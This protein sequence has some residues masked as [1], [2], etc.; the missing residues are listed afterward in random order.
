[1]KGIIL[2]FNIRII[3]IISIDPYIRIICMPKTWT[4]KPPI[5][6]ELVKQRLHIQPLVMQL[7]FNLGIIA[8]ERIKAFLTPNYESLHD[9]FV[10][11]DME[12]AVDRI[13]RA[14]DAGEKIVVYGDYDADAVTANAVLQQTF[15]Y[16]NVPAESYIPD[17]FTE[18]YG[19]NVP[20]FE[21]LKSDGARVV[22]TVDCG[23]NS[24]DAAD[25]CTSHDID[26]IITDHHEITGDV[27]KSFALINPKNPSDAYPDNQITG[28]GVAYKL[29]VGL[30]SRAEKV[31]A[32]RTA[33]GQDYVPH[34]DKWLL[35]LVAI[36]TVADCHSLL[37]ENRILVKYGLHV[38]G[39]TKWLG[40]R[41]LMEA[42]GVNSPGKTLDTHS[43]GFVIAPRINAAGRLEHAGRALDLLLATDPLKARDLTIQLEQINVRRQDITVRLVSEGKE[44]AEHMLDRKV[45]VLA[46]NDW[47]K[48]VVGLVAGR[49][50]NEFKRPVIA[51]SKEGDECTGSAR[52]FG[53][54]DI[55]ECLKSS[56]E[57]LVKFGGHK[58]A[59]GLT[60]K[61]KDL[62][63]FYGAVLRY[64]DE[65]MTETSESVL[66]LDAELQSTDLSINTHDL[67]AEL[68]PFGVGNPKPIF[69]LANC[70]VETQRAV[71]SDQQHLQMAL[72][73]DGVPVESI[74][75]N[76]AR[77]CDTIK[78]GDTVDIA[79]ELLADAWNGYR[80]FKL[81]IVDIK[82]HELL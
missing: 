6:E 27:P 61:T 5:P 10:F 48:G 65:H 59:A 71:G 50:C 58:Q 11:V 54:F 52:T 1:M 33:A 57:F 29:A 35:D 81:R 62:D 51:L 63:A 46:A 56:K 74:G 72:S 49:L 34:W 76:L 23:T 4:L 43:I 41:S 53:D 37:G 30:L 7:L 20:A 66:E 75:F 69:L 68:G 22:I 31:K 17:R 25:Y 32:R 39:K 47:P 9:P 55:I 28:V 14:I 3:S 36:G 45:L 79:C 16:L 44:M 77:V 2:I 15:R 24:V 40:L 38:L 21:K 19:L 67:V 18:G 64:A 82:L 70:R 42:T 12:K 73:K 60:L 8:T 13:W 80:K 78:V 26:L